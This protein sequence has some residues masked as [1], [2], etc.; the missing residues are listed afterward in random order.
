VGDSSNGDRVT[1]LRR[2]DP[3]P[4]PP[5]EEE[6]TRRV[7]RAPPGARALAAEQAAAHRAG[8][9]AARARQENEQLISSGKVV[10]ARITIALD[11]RGLEGPEVDAACGGAEPDVDMWELGLAVPAP[12]QVVKLAELTGFPGAFF[13]QPV[14][15]GPL[16]G[17]AI[18]I[19]HRG[20]RGCEALEP[21][22]VDENWVLLY[23]GKPRELP[24]AAAQGRLF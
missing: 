4:L 22:V 3:G 5:R 21:D 16:A 6:L 24:P 19:C 11:F 8:Y 20:R 18:F 10:P 13:Y 12:E 14:K 2:G 1:P 23:G 9:A 15:P 17:S 7:Q